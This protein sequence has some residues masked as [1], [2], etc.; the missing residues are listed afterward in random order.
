MLEIKNITKSFQ[1][2]G[3][4]LNELTLT[5]NEGD[6]I[7]IAGPSGSGKTTLLNIIGLL[8]RPD[9]GDLLFRGVRILDYDQD[10]SAS[11]RNK[12]IGF[13]FQE[14]LLLPYLTVK[15]NILLPLLA[16]EISGNEFDKRVEDAEEMMKKTGITEL[17]GK[18]PDQISG[19]E[20]QRATLVRA[21]VNRPSILLADEPTGSLDR[22]NAENLGDLLVRMNNEY[23][24]TLIVATHSAELAGKM[25]LRYNLSEGKLFQVTGMQK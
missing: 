5:V 3:V 7:S 18:Y 4:V 13:V 9:S 20:A 2:R 15:E 24:I 25:K 10:S 1:Q 17:A 19:G 16:S 23:G 6:S 12:N 22:K 14:H 21:L 11:Y 8:D